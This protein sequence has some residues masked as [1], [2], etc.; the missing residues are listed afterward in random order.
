MTVIRDSHHPQWW[1]TGIGGCSTLVHF[2]KS[3]KK[4]QTDARARTGQ[5][6]AKSGRT[7]S[8]I[9][10]RVSQNLLEKLSVKRNGNRDY[11]TMINFGNSIY[12]S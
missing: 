9:C 2:R 1:N 5:K 8:K 6:I 11:N 4:R 3:E 12:R 10:K 7:N